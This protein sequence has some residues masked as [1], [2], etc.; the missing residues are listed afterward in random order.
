MNKFT[1]ET[2]KEQTS[3]QTQKI[4]AWLE[5]VRRNPA[6][7]LLYS[8]LCGMTLWP[9]I[10]AMQKGQTLGA[11]MALG[12]AAAGVGG[13][14]LAN[15]VQHWKDQADEA[16]V[17]QWV[18]EQAPNNPELRD[19][20]DDILEKLD[21]IPQARAGLSETERDWFNQ[22][23]QKELAQLGN[24]KRFEATL[25]GSGAIAQ[26]HSVAATTGGVAVGGDVHGHIVTGGKS[27]AFDQRGQQVKRQTNI[28]GD[29]K[30]S[31]LPDE[32]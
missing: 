29:W 32:E 15:Q 4:K 26:N 18:V 25:T 19:A 11:M 31:N 12:T 2:W 16:T 21:A 14:L 22:T 27:T 6:P 20:L 23:L 1:L 5:R 8:G 9:L 30:R 10:D 7:Y 3:K 17:A 28:A 24:L 13:N